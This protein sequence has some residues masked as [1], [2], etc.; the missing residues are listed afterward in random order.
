MTNLRTSA[1]RDLELSADEYRLRP[2]VTIAAGPTFHEPTARELDRRA[3]LGAEREAHQSANVNVTAEDVKSGW[4]STLR[5]FL[6]LTKEKEKYN[7][8]EKT[9]VAQGFAFA[10]TEAARERRKSKHGVEAAKGS[11]DMFGSGRTAN[12]EAAYLMT[13]QGRHQMHASLTAGAAE[14]NRRER[15]DHGRVKATQ[16]AAFGFFFTT[17][18]KAKN[19]AAH[20]RLQAAKSLFGRMKFIISRRGAP[21]R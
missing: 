1:S 9:T 4:F 18:R 21:P 7:A 10:S 19:D 20:P 15:D 6:S 3:K 5:D 16:S 17:Q 2:K 11:G 8:R 12:E 14:Y 13:D